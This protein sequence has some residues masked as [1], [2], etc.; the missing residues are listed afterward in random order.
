MGFFALI[1]AYLELSVLLLTEA[2]FLDILDFIF[3]SLRLFFR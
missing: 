3:S 1:L 2:Q